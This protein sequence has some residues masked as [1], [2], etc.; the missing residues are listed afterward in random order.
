M[1]QLAAIAIVAALVLCVPLVDA[2]AKAVDGQARMPDAAIGIDAQSMVSGLG[3][4]E[5]LER[6]ESFAPARGDVPTWFQDEIGLL[7]G[8]RDVRSAASVIGYLVDGEAVETCALLEA[9]MVQRGWSCVPLGGVDGFTCMKPSGACTWVLA[10]C[11]QV[12]SATSVVMRCN[13]S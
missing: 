4:D 8:A 11:T 6:L 7:S 2:A 10:T 13:V 1:R 3:A 9:H 12:G 5:F